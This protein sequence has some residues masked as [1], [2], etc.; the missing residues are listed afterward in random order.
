M[1]VSMFDRTLTELDHVRLSKLIRR[2]KSGRAASAR[3]SPIE[4]VL[5][6]ADIVHWRRV[7][8]NVVTM[9][10]RVLVKDPQTGEQSQLTLC[11]PDDADARSGYVSVLSPAGWSLLGQKVGATVHWPTPSGDQR[12]AEILGMLF[13]PESSGVHAM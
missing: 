8:P 6:E 1:E 9:Y 11:Y 12:A 3:S 13:Q 4:Q 7:P 10:S 5:E 2:H